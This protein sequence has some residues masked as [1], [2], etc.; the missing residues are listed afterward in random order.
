M[1]DQGI[2]A[3]FPAP[4][5]H[6]TLFTDA[7]VRQAKDAKADTDVDA[8]A[9]DGDAGPA[10]LPYLQPPAPPNEDYTIFG[11]RIPIVDRLQSLAEAGIERLP[12][13]GSDRVVELKKLS[14]SLLVKF[15]DIVQTMGVDPEQ[16]PGKLQDV[17][18][19]LLNIHNLVNEYRPQQTR[20]L[21]IGMMRDQLA[22]GQA[23]IATLEKH[24]DE[25]EQLIERYKGSSSLLAGQ[26]QDR[27]TTN[28]AELDLWAE[29]AAAAI[30]TTPT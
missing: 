3:A 16:F 6:Y 28:R 5:A 9:I 13:E 23:E 21:L 25:T 19:L 24:C 12:A 15:L 14:R 17:R 4:P 20:E 7:A 29:L 22:Q 11:Q 2:S 10:L 30:K 26:T 1:A 8:I 27:N 18:L